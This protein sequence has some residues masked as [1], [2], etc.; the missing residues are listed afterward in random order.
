MFNLFVSILVLIV[1]VKLVKDGVEGI[2]KFA[3]KL[4]KKDD[5]KDDE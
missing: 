3:N 1:G 5:K 2:G 4:F